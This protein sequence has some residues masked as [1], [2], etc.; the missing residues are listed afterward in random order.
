[1]SG[2]AVA[3]TPV[4]QPVIDSAPDR[5][6]YGRGATITGHLE[7]WTAGDEVSLQRLRGDVWN[8]LATKAVD[9]AGAVRFTVTDLY[10]TAAFRLA[11]TDPMTEEETVSDWAKVAVRPKLTLRLSTNHV[12]SG[13][14]VS[15]S[16]RLLPEGSARP[17]VLQQKVGGRWRSLGTA[18]AREGSY[19]LRFEAR[20]IGY[21]PVRAIF[22]GDASNTRAR[23]TAPLRVYDPALATW[24]GPGFYGNSTACGQTLTSSTVGVAHRWLPCGTKVSVLFEGKTIVVP[25]IDRGPYTDAEWDLTQEAA[26]RL[27][28]SGTDTIGV[29]RSN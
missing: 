28:F 23:E 21:H 17:V 7:G 8:S 3:Q 20:R 6:G 27:G 22:R 15:V 24:Y 2:T 25:V 16:G 12:M 11:Y 1:M 4:K 14:T 29:V 5:V 26:E 18:Y 9:E 13:R 19:A 10:R